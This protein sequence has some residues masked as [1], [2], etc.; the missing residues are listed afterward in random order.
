M[1][2]QAYNQSIS[3]WDTLVLGITELFTSTLICFFI[4]FHITIQ[5]QVFFKGFKKSAISIWQMVT[6]IH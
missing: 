3:L 6:Q 2:T 4:L 1:L 5:A